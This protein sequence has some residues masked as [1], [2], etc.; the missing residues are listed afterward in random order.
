MALLLAVF[1]LNLF[2]RTSPGQCHLRSYEHTR[3]WYRSLCILDD[4]VF[5]VR[6]VG[7]RVVCCVTHCAHPCCKADPA[8]C[9]TPLRH[10][11]FVQ[12]DATAFNSFLA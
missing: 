9:L 7:G 8:S 5:A 4:R 3:G 6:G 2:E 11:T 1:A 12:T 10:F